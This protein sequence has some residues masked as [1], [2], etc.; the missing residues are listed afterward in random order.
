[1]RMIGQLKQLNHSLK[2]RH[3]EFQTCERQRYDFCSI[4]IFVGSPGDTF[5]L[6]CFIIKP[7]I[8]CMPAMKWDH[9]YEFQMDAKRI[10]T[11]DLLRDIITVHGLDDPLEA[12]TVKELFS[13]PSRLHWGR[14]RNRTQPRGLLIWDFRVG[15]GFKPQ[16]PHQPL[17]IEHSCIFLFNLNF[18]T[19]TWYDL[20]WP[21]DLHA[22]SHLICYWRPVIAQAE[23]KFKS[24]FGF[25]FNLLWITM[26]TVENLVSVHLC[27][28][29]VFTAQIVRSWPLGAP[30]LKIRVRKLY[31]KTIFKASSSSDIFEIPLRHIQYNNGA[32]IPCMWWDLLAAPP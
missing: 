12:A 7:H 22:G 28:Q 32:V 30:S 13:T 31:W 6:T 1:M 3:P 23:C 4:Y 14:G 19:A 25:F 17:S 10:E 27:V 29:A 15:C 9:S 2:F 8:Y 16:K 5:K 24:Y 21:Y 11:A 18:N 20:C 26:Q